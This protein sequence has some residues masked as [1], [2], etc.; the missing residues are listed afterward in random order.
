VRNLK[1]Q[2]KI[3]PSKSVAMTRY[4]KGKQT[5]SVIGGIGKHAQPVF[6]QKA[7]IIDEKH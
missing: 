6:P 1:S 4:K 7:A 3:L 5:E 2:N